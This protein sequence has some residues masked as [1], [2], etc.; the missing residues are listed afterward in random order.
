MD[1]KQHVELLAQYNQSMNGSLCFSAQS[2]SD[3][4]LKEDRKAFFGSILG[5]LN[6]IMVGDIVWLR[7]FSAH[8]PDLSSLK[9]LKHW[10]QPKALTDILFDSISTLQEARRQLDD[11]V[12]EFVGQLHIEHFDTVLHYQNMK[13]Q[14]QGKAFSMVLQHFFNHQTHHRGQVTTL[15]SQSAIDVGVTDLL[16]LIPD[17]D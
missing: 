11:I 9:P 16:V 4:A 14:T 15:L 5:T 13:G 7:R 3:D 6:H 10:P 1:L 17:A 8:L 2:L 12:I